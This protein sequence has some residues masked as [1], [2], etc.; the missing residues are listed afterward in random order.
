MLELLSTDTHSWEQL[1]EAVS[2]DVESRLDETLS[3]LQAD[4]RIRYSA[5]HGGYA[6]VEGA[7]E[8]GSRGD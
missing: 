2:E 3:E 5:R 1:L 8:G 6:I 4:N 7:P